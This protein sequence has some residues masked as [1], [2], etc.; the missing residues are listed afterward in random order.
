MNIKRAFF[1][2]CLIIGIFCTSLVKA[3]TIKSQNLSSVHIDELSDAQIRRFSA[4]LGASGLADPQLEQRALSLGMKPEEIRKLKDRVSRLQKEDQ[5]NRLKNASDSK[6][7]NSSGDS[8]RTA[9]GSDTLSMAD[10]AL[11]E[12]R[13]KIFGADLFTTPSTTF[14]PNIRIATPLNYQVGPDDELLIDIFGFSEASYSLKVSPEGAI[15]V[16]YVG[17]II[18][19]GMAIEQAT[20]RIRTRLSTIYS[21]LKT[22][23]TK[24]KVSLGNIR[25]IKVVLTGELV[26]PG[27]Y[28]LPSVG[29]VFNAL[30]QSGGPSENGS[31][32]EIEVI[33][34]GVK[35][36][37]MD[38]YD[39]LFRGEF[40]N[41]IR[42]QDQDVIRVPTYN[43]RVE[44][45]GEVKR[46]GIFEMVTGENMNDLLRFSGNFTERAY[47][48]RIK[49]LKNTATER[50]I[51]DI[52]AEEF[53][54]YQPAP[55]DKFFVD[56]ILDRFENRI[57]IEGS[58]FRPGQ[59]EL[60]P[61]MTLKQLLQKAEGLTEDA[62]LDRAYITR[63]SNDLQP[64]LISIDINA[65]LTGKAKDI[66]LQRED[67]VKIA[68]LFDLKEEYNVKVEGEVRQPGKYKFAEGM[69]VEDVIVQAGGFREGAASQ[70]IEVSRRVK[71]SNALS[72]SA[73]IA[74]VFQI[75]INQN[76]KIAAAA[77]VLMPFDIVSVRPSIGFELQVQVK[78]QGE[79]LYP[80]VYTLSKKD[81]RISDII[82]RAGGFTAWAYPEG[83][84]LLR[85]GVIKDKAELKK[86]ENKSL[87]KQLKQK[88]EGE[89]G[90]KAIVSSFDT[91]H[92]DSGKVV[93]NDFIGID[94]PEILRKPGTKLDLFLE[95]GDVLN[96]PKELQ[97]VKISGEVLSPVTVVYSQ[98]KTFRSYIASAGGFTEKSRRK[99]S[100]IK[101]ANGSMKS[102]KKIIF[103]NIYPRV[104]SGSEIIVPEGAVRRSISI[105]ELVGVT[106]SLLTLYIL[107]KSLK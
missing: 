42:L 91:D 2:L 9:S 58:V 16:P 70:R 38:V 23:N 92:L 67:V 8:L 33:R 78:V 82:N 56:E 85:S 45:V 34:G 74:E 51:S 60:A 71:N 62:F 36:A 95:V 59:F 22:G 97:T 50:K 61:G 10:K 105:T 28:T 87:D 3:Q 88:G 15:N 98:N 104:R 84:S 103:F 11:V 106:T 53:A 40:K 13:S 57:M 47:Q 100:Y 55:G 68:S 96:I 4:Q 17:V 26:K 6:T 27:T 19:G 83:A 89:K 1:Y 25:S 90:E 73:Q 86:E 52:I 76:F 31:F 32:R 65:I 94:L 24:V 14:E 46:P 54:S 44:I 66:L 41:N 77:F 63:L 69:T 64:Q 35:I 72:T 29:S 75:D 101:Y 39:F 21:G 7:F 80:G 81:E 48:A 37:T 18:V 43:K 93:K 79:V 107:L 5:S 12:L 30:Y 49:V 102:A 99:R 20:S